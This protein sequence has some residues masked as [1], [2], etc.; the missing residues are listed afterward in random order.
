MGTFKVGGRGAE[1]SEAS[2]PLTSGPGGAHPI[3]EGSRARASCRTGYSQQGAPQRL[4][5]SWRASHCLPGTNVCR[6]L[7]ARRVAWK[8]E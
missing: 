4:P 6:G 5:F 3:F 8:G 2:A 1:V 7:A